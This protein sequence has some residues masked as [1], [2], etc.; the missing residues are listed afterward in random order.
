MNS[1][2]LTLFAVP[3]AF[4]GDMEWIQTNAIQSWTKLDPRPDIL[5]LGS[6]QGTAEI[7][8]KLSV[9]HIPDIETSEYGTPLM[10]SIFQRAEACARTPWLAYINAD[11]LLLDDFS[12]A[13]AILHG[14]LTRQGMSEFLLSS[15]RVEIDIRQAIDYSDAAWQAQIHDEV[16][17]RGVLDHKTAIELFLYSRGLFSDIPPFAIGRPCWDNW[18]VWSV[19]HRQMPIIDATEAFRVVHQ[20]HDY[21]HVAGGGRKTRQGEEAQRN[22]RLA[23]GRF[24]SLDIACTHVLNETGLTPGRTPDRGMRD[25]LVKRRLDRGL[26]EFNRGR[27]QEALDYFDDALSRSGSLAVESLHLIRAVCFDRL[28]S[29]DEAAKALQEE[30]TAF[31]GNEQARQMLAR[32]TQDD[33]QE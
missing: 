10:H 30:L 18:M 25:T 33:D 3:K 27:Y 8:R 9:G 31:P 32:L 28:G 29:P 24:M 21:G 5:L 4:M 14:E 26:E 17:N 19:W 1:H 23:Q 22:I 11:C 15:Q 6:D 20:C 12:R 2:I 16:A 13:L 7:A